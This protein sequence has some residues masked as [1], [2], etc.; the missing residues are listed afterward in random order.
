MFHL[1]S[2]RTTLGNPNLTSCSCAHWA[3]LSLRKIAY[4]W[5]RLL[6]YQ[7]FD[8]DYE[9]L[10][11]WWYVILLYWHR[12]VFLT[13]FSW[14]CRTLDIEDVEASMKP[15]GLRIESRS[16]LLGLNVVDVTCVHMIR[17]YDDWLLLLSWFIDGCRMMIACRPESHVE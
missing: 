6:Y 9:T 17:G 4:K 8:Y 13:G 2:S 7:S 12:Q 5:S 16:G 1:S 14:V 11:I 10:W 15:L 3:N